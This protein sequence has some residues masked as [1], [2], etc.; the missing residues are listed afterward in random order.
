[1][2]NLANLARPAVLDATAL[3]ALMRN[4]PGAALVASCLGRAV[5]CAVNQAE[6]H[7]ALVSAGLDPQ[8]AWW[9][10]AQIECESVPFDANLAMIAGGLA[11][12][13]RPLGLSSSDRACLAL[14]ID[15]QAAVYTT[16]QAWR[17]LPGFKLDLDVVVIA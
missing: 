8:Q 1:M 3:L 4:E 2:D 9:H 14:A 15:R 16:S 5:I 11:R 17:A 13:T 6:V 12:I 10:I 7:A